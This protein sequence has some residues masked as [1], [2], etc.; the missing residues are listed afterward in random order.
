MLVY[1]GADGFTSTLQE[2]LFEKK[3]SQSNQMLY[4]NLVSALISLITLIPDGS[5]VSSI[6]FG[7]RHPPMIFDAITLSFAASLGSFPRCT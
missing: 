4:V 3:S 2:R 1:L 6:A 7:Q 5:I